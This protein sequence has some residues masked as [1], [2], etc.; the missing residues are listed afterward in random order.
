MTTE[1]VNTRRLYYFEYAYFRGHK[2]NKDLPINELRKQAKQL[3]KQITKKPIPKIVAGQG[4][5][6]NGRYMSYSQKDVGIVLTRSQR[7]IITLIH[8]LTHQLNYDMHDKLFI[9]AYFKLLKLKG[10]KPQELKKIRKQY[11]LA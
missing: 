4:V 1:S 2:L 5:Y 3:W 11:K 10:F 8:E 7:N 9:N 6:F